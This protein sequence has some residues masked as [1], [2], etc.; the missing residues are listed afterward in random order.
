MSGVKALL[1]GSSHGS[2][3]VRRGGGLGVGPLTVGGGRLEVRGCGCFLRFQSLLEAEVAGS[4]W[5]VQLQP[6]PPRLCGT[7]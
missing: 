5:I 3:P 6:G 4:Q 7:Q 1:P 2:H